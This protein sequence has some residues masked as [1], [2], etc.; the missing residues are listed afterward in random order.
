MRRAIATLRRGARELVAE[1]VSLRFLGFA[2]PHVAP[3]SG[4]VP[5]DC[6]PALELRW[7]A[8]GVVDRMPRHRASREQPSPRF[9]GIHQLDGSIGECAASEGRPP[10]TV[11]VAGAVSDVC[12]GT[13]PPLATASDR[14]VL[15]RRPVQKEVKWRPNRRNWLDWNVQPSP[16]VNFTRACSPA[17]AVPCEF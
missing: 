2:D 15:D 8:I 5:G 7:V 17:H 10:A 6:V 1:E 3:L 9:R 4:F 12:H 14:F 11:R 13:H 16:V